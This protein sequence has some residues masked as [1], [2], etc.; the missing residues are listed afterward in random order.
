MVVLRL[1][2][3]LYLRPSDLTNANNDTDAAAAGI[4]VGQVYYR[5]GSQFD[6]RVS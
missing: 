1:K 3:N 5:N 4:V 2:V 6:M